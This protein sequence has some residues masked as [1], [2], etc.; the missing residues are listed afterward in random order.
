[1]QCE[2]RAPG[3]GLATLSA[4]VGLFSG[5]NSPMQNKV[6]VSVESFS[7]FATFIGLLSCM[8]SLVLREV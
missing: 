6:L 3:E 1:M 7:T 5:V 8:D 2:G 4:L